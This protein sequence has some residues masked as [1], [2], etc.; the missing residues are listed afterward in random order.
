M[1]RDNEAD[2]GAAEAEAAEDDED[3]AA[4][5]GTI[6]TTAL[7]NPIARLTGPMDDCVETKLTDEGGTTG[8]L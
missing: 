1:L 7:F 6:E 3:A 8:P 4:E 2:E 5:G